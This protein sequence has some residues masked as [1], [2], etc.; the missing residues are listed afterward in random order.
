M[1]ELNY[2]SE[3]SKSDILKYRRRVPASLQLALGKKE[4]VIS[5][6]TASMM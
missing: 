5:F 4:F 3:D 6:K 2:V 1:I